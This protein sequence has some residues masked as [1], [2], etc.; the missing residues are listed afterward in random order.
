MYYLHFTNNGSS[1]WA[2][3]MEHFEAAQEWGRRAPV[4]RYDRCFAIET[5]SQATA[6]AVHEAVAALL[7]HGVRPEAHKLRS[8]TRIS[9]IAPFA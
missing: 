4:S 9:E 6:N 3:T 2:H 7:A 1:I 5:T 8:T